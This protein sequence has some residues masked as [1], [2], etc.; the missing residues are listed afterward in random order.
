MA[1]PGAN[2][3]QLAVGVSD[4]PFGPRDLDG[5]GGKVRLDA[6]TNSVYVSYPLSALASGFNAHIINGKTRLSQFFA[7]A[8][9]MIQEP[10]VANLTMLNAVG[11]A[12][13]NAPN[14]TVSPATYLAGSPSCLRVGS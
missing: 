2:A 7:T 12:T 14:F 1:V 9:A 3:G 10:D 11:L 6:K 8:D 4:G 13:D 5:I